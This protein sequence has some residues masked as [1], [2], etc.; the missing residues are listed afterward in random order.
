MLWIDLV[1]YLSIQNPFPGQEGCLI[2][3]LAAVSLGLIPSAAFG[4]GRDHQLSVHPKLLN[5]WGSG[6]W[7]SHGLHESIFSL[8][9]TLEEDQGL[10]KGEKRSED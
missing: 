5:S 2:S 7:D 10:H 8:D 6:L 9:R 3:F 4:L 1:P